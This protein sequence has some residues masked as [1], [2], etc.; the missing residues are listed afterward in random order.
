VT[1]PL[2]GESAGVQTMLEKGA[3]VQ[4]MLPCTFLCFSQLDAFPPRKKQ[5]QLTDRRLQLDP[6]F[7]QF[8]SPT[9]VERTLLKLGLALLLSGKGVH[10]HRVA[11]QLVGMMARKASD[12]GSAAFSCAKFR[13]PCFS[14][15]EGLSPPKR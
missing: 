13:I 10:M 9:M 12:D 4:A 6:P 5:V 2:H 3:A 7:F 14:V 11:K 15:L 8:I 1:L